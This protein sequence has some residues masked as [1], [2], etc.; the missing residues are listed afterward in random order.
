[1]NNATGL[2]LNK[3]KNVKIIHNLSHEERNCSQL[4]LKYDLQSPNQKC[5]ALECCF[6]QEHVCVL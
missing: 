6:P 5:G 1:M 4:L 2:N 3:S